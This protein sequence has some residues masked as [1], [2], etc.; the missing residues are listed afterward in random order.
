MRMGAALGYVKMREALTDYFL[1][2]YC[3]SK[4]HKNIFHFILV[5]LQ[6]LKKYSTN[7]S[8]FYQS[9][10]GIW[11][12][13]GKRFTFCLR[14]AKCIVIPTNISQ[15]GIVVSGRNEVQQQNVKSVFKSF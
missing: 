5:T 13:P 8:R 10:E 3:S 15:I 6:F 14:E 9:Y 4:W 12:S 7:V 2:L 11:I 1:K